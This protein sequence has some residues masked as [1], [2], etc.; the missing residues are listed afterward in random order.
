MVDESHARELLYEATRSLI[1]L[2]N[3]V[4]VKYDNLPECKEKERLK[5]AFNEIIDMT[6][7]NLDLLFPERKNHKKKILRSIKYL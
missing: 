2:Q 5:D 4:Y 1:D 3:K 7:A 6:Q